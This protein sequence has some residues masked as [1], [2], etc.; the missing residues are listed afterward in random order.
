MTA[1]MCI[2]YYG[3]YMNHKPYNRC[4]VYIVIHYST[5]RQDRRCID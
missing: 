2:N 3:R 1:S 4:P 5:D